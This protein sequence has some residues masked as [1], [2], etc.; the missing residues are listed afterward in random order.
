MLRYS[1]G[2][3]STR[4][5]SQVM[6]HKSRYRE[7]IHGSDIRVIPQMDRGLDL[8]PSLEYLEWYYSHYAPELELEPDLELEPESELHSRVVLIIQIRG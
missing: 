4:T 2:S 5:L 1:W 8:Q 3:L 6:E 7:V